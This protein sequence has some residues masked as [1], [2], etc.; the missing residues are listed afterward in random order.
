MNRRVSRRVAAA[1]LGLWVL[2]A[3]AA[4][5][6]VPSIGATAAAAAPDLTVIST[7]RYDVQPSKRR[8]HVT[9]DL[10]AKNHHT[11]TVI[12]SYFFD[13]VVLG[14]LPD[15]SGFTVSPPTGSAAHP[16][17]HVTSRTSARVLVSV[18]FGSKLRSGRTL[19]L[20]LTFD[21]LDKGGAVD[22]PVRVGGAIAT[23]PV[24]AVGTPETPG[25]KVSVTVPSDYRIEVLGSKLA[26]P[27]KG[28]TGTKAYTSVA[29]SAPAVFGAYVLA[30][31][32]GA[33][34]STPVNV[35]AGGA[36]YSLVVRSWQ[37]DAAFGSRTATLFRKALPAL[38]TLIGVPPGAQGADG[39]P[40]SVEEAVT[41]S[42]GG[43]AALFDGGT[44]RIQIA[45][46]AAPAVVLH[47]AAHAWFN[48]GFVAD[49]WMAEGF[50]SY[51]ASRAAGPLKIKVAA[52]PLTKALLARR[53]PLNAW[54][55]EGTPDPVVDAYGMAAS[56]GLA[57]LIADRIGPNGLT[58]VWKAIE[59]GE[60]ADQPGVGT[61]PAT[62][63][64]D[65]G[66]A[67]VPDWRILLDL[68]ETRTGK[69]VTDLW[70]AWVVRPEDE[71]MLDRRKTVRAAYRVLVQEAGDWALPQTIRVALDRWQFDQAADMIARTRTVLEARP[72]LQT[73]ADGIGVQLPSTLRTIFEGSGGPA[74]A[75]TELAAERAAI[76][77]LAAA[78]AT[79]P[80]D[81]MLLERLGLVGTDPEAGIS[82]ARAAFVA[83]DL[84]GAVLA[85]DRAAT[86]WVGAV[87]VG[88]GRLAVVAAI[89]ATFAGLVLLVTAT[90][91]RRSR[92]RW[93][94][95]AG[96]VIR[97]MGPGS[98]SRPRAAL[99]PEP[100]VG[101]RS[102]AVSISP[103]V[104][105]STR[106]ALHVSPARVPMAHR[107]PATPEGLAG[108]PTTAW[109][110][111]GAVPPT[112]APEVPPGAR[113]RPRNV[114]APRGGY[115][116]LA[117]DLPADR[118]SATPSGR[119]ASGRRPDAGS[120]PRDVPPVAEPGDE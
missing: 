72:A 48:G 13:R 58:A 54:A 118:S 29:L 24:W 51:Y 86:I 89:L 70:R 50:A 23:F 46:D 94:Y 21:L 81:P 3:V 27:S 85:A 108:P 93:S 120:R 56:V 117:A 49:R 22:R 92:S 109:P 36:K 1:T 5:V 4:P 74:A 73:A 37:D 78:I 95:R 83:G 32:P 106:H 17:V 52:L 39:A 107:L 75:A 20:R 41:R 18:A 114:V 64:T 97:S 40:L 96:Q 61:T 45:Y 12:R 7:A 101:P 8:I 76:D 60:M 11:D 91:D 119:E 100:K 14:F 66:G 6:A 9:V 84:S 116:T 90:R 67:S 35:T 43:Y 57:K 103:G 62:P 115:G 77:R 104:Q 98:G 30:D 110:R 15:A 68:V 10:T 111:Y 44:A 47:E 88:R 53:I 71:S 63:E 65:P 16:T 42:A 19:A 105:V 38:G 34:R 87:D 33:Y 80:A 25:S 2:A 102:G 69:D 26:G 31:R 113:P 55:A 79:R 112:A 82:A 59:A 99:A 28:P